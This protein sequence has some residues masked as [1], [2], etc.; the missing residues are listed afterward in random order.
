MTQAGSLGKG[1]PGLEGLL[2]IAMARLPE[3]HQDPLGDDAHVALWLLPLWEEEDL[4]SSR[5]W[6]CV[7][8]IS[9]NH[10]Q[11]SDLA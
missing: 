1:L 3:L 9:Q 6:V 5:L 7:E 8:C 4:L 10:W 11:H 2:S